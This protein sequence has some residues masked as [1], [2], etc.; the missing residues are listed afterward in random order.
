LFEKWTNFD[1]LAVW[2]NI[3]FLPKYIQI[4]IIWSKNSTWHMQ[5]GHRVIDTFKAALNIVFW[6]SGQLQAIINDSYDILNLSNS[7]NKF[8]FR[9]SMKLNF[10]ALK[11]FNPNK[12][13]L[14]VSITTKSVD[15]DNN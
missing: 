12:S 15:I 7:Y 9:H 10:N 5:E 2:T 1:C 8:Q 14:F 3:V 11:I 4:S 6:F 13:I